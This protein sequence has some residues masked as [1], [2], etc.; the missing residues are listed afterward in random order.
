MTISAAALDRLNA[1][2][3]DDADK[4]VDW[5]AAPG[6]HTIVSTSFGP[7]AAVTLHMATQRQPE[8]P[9]LWVDAGYG[10]PA[11]YRFADELSALLKLNLKIYRPRR[12]RAHREAADGPLPGLADP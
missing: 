10:T 3:G 6:R 1:E 9:V 12:S 2:L 8:I 4:L 7:F 11:M 5:A